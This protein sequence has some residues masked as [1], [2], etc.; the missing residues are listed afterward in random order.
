MF[1]VHLSKSALKSMETCTPIS[2]A[3]ETPLAGERYALCKG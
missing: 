1:D 2:Q 3:D